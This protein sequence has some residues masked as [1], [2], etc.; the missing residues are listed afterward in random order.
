MQLGGRFVFCEM[1]A[2]HSRRGSK[3]LM[4]QR[5]YAAWRS[6][7]SNKIVPMQRGA[8]SARR[9]FGARALPCYVFQ[10][11]GLRRFYRFAALALWCFVFQ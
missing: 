2:V 10:Y 1:R 8:Q 4:G 7:F 5:S 9:H 3:G 6:Y 11:L